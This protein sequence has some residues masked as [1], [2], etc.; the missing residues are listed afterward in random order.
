MM[1]DFGLQNKIHWFLLS[2]LS[3][4]SVTEYTLDWT[5]PICW[6][7]TGIEDLRKNLGPDSDFLPLLLGFLC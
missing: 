1:D 7:W 5:G 3:L 4:V 2:R 6:E